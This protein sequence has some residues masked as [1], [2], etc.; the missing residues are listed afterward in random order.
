MDFNKDL[1]GDH[2]MTIEEY[3]DSGK[4]YEVSTKAS[5]GVRIMPCVNFK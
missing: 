4:G 1:A 3:L 5:Q 2:D